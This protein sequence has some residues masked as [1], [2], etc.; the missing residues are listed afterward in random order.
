MIVSTEQFI[1]DFKKSSYY[2]RAFRDHNII[3]FFVSGS[4]AT[5]ILDERSDFDLIAIT[6]NSTPEEEPMEYLTYK[7]LKVHWY[8][9]PLST[10]ILGGNIL[11]VPM[12]AM[13][14]LE[15]AF[16]KDNII[17]YQNPRYNTIIEYLNNVKDDIGQIGVK[18]L[19]ET[20]KKQ[21][22]TILQQGAILEKN[23]TKFLYY[24]CVA[25]TY[26]TEKQLDNKFLNAVKR[27]R[28]QPISDEYKQ[29]AFDYINN[30]NEYI[31]LNETDAAAMAK[32]INDNL[33]QLIDSCK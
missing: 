7:G 1:I 15:F 29:R 28:W 24:L 19:Y 16:I 27:I 26:A 8:W 21:I 12:I 3:L 14:D 10:F 25:V 23:Y 2:E 31:K 20:Q 22:E 4:R 17:L 5:G 13:G 30:L 6:D 9:R 11:S 33:L 18:V 32:T